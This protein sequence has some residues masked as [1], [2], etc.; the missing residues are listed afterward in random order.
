MQDAI[1]YIY[2]PKRAEKIITSYPAIYQKLKNSIYKQQKSF[3]F[4]Q[5]MKTKLQIYRIISNQHYPHLVEILKALDACIFNGWEQPTLLKTRSSEDFSSALTELIVAHYFLNR[6]FKISSFD[7]RKGSTSVPDILVESGSLSASIEAY[8]P[9]NWP[10][11]DLLQEELMHCIK[12]LDVPWDFSFKIV[13][14][15][16]SNFDIHH[17]L[18]HLDLW[19]ISAANEKPDD[20]WPS[21]APLISKIETD[22]SESKPIEI[23]ASHFN[24]SVNL[25]IQAI[26]SDIEKSRFHVPKRIGT[27]SNIGSSGYAP[28]YMF[29]R[30]VKTRVLK[31]VQKRQAGSL[32]G[33]V[34]KVLFVDI[35]RLG[36]AQE[37][38][39]P[40]YLKRFG[41]SIINDIVPSLTSLDMVIFGDTRQNLARNMAIPLLFRKASVPDEVFYRLFGENRSFIE[42][43]KEVFIMSL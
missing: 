28:E 41:T 10:G 7:Q 37:F 23:S 2:D 21:I 20:R 5:C 26:L 15:P 31:K 43:S 33:V 24:D 30:L 13:L 35:S 22:L 42:L 12:Y 18:L 14:K 4:P 1:D 11:I 32:Q 19:E 16:I 9:R 27:I 34:L 38:M 39:H 25:N 29:D 3:G 17:K 36:Y 8:C 6:G 40:Y